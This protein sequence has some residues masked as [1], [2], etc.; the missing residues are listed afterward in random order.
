MIG[1]REMEKVNLMSVICVQQR[2]Y[3]RFVV[4]S[5]AVYVGCSTPVSRLAGKK[6]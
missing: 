2:G 4:T 6:A 5:K 3:M 1:Q